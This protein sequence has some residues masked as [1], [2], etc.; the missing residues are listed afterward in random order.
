MNYESMGQFIIYFQQK[1]ILL[2]F[3]K[4]KNYIAGGSHNAVFLDVIWDM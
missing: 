2:N 4:S 3:C 1:H